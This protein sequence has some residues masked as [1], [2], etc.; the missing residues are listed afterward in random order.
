MFSVGFFA[1]YI[2]YTNVRGPK[3][4]KID[5]KSNNFR[6]VSIQRAGSEKQTR[7]VSIKNSKMLKREDSRISVRSNISEKSV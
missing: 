2:V 7:S 1:V 5:K 3:H 6:N 4:S